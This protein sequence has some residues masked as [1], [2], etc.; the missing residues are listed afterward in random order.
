MTSIRESV[1]RG[2]SL[3]TALRASPL[4]LPPVV[5]GI[6]QA[7]EAGSGLPEAV[8]RAAELAE[9]NAA[10]Q[11]AIRSAL[12]Y[13][14]VLAVA[15]L[16]SVGLLVG[17]VLPRFAAILADLGQALPPATRMVLGVA[18]F[19]RAGAIPVLTAVGLMVVSWRIWTASDSGR[20]KWHTILLGL[21]VIGSVR[22]SAATAR[23][24]AAAAALLD[25]GV[26]IAVA[27]VHASATAGD[28]AISARLLEAREA[29]MR[30]EGVARALAASKA[31]TP[32]AVRL[33]RTGEE[34]GRLAAML[35]HAARI[36][37]DRA[38]R[39]VRSAVRMLEPALILAFA[40]L[41]ALVSAALLQAVYS[42]RPTP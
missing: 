9:S 42:V 39:T 1:R 36:E 13:P 19:A 21:P 20:Q 26:P 2:D 4:G 8:R 10:V 17:I 25:T 5:I 3:A 33:V 37:A 16:A 7:G 29:V 30:G 31:A 23:T 35:A 40:A 24:A 18:E 6:I 28:A 22:L 27:L 12:V 38:E 15:G 32:T 41:V 14:A 11:A 34:T